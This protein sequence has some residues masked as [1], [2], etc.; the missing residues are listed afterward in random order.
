MERAQ[1]S[2]ATPGQSFALRAHVF[3]TR[4]SVVHDQLVK[5]Q[6]SCSVHTP[7]S[8]SQNTVKGC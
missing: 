3:E 7:L 2:S 5:R 1:I 6:G 8:L 4:A